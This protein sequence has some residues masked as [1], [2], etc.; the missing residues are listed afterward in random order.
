MDRT[1]VIGQVNLVV[2]DLVAAIAFYRLLGFE[3]EEMGRP[4]WAPHHARIITQGGVRIELDSIAFPRQWKSRTRQGHRQ[5]AALFVSV[6]SRDEVDRCFTPRQR[7]VIGRKNRRRR[8]LGRALC[9][10]GRS[11][12]SRGRIHE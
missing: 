1:P 5:R 11:R 6:A 12:R 2:S 10:R 9:D 7:P 8:I 4:E 3:V